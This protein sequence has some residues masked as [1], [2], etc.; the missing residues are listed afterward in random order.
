MLNAS[1]ATK[2]ATLGSGFGRRSSE[3]IFV[4]SS[5]AVTARHCEWAD[6]AFRL[7]IDVTVWRGLHGADEGLPGGAAFQA[8]KFFGGDDDDFIARGGTIP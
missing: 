6:A 1:S 3:S 2:L 8:A 7:D 4:S 5:H